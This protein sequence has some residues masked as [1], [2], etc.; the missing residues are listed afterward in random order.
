MVH[1]MTLSDYLHSFKSVWGA[2][3]GLSVTLAALLKFTPLVP[4]WPD[5]AGI[6]ASMLAVVA[7]LLGVSVGFFASRKPSA[8]A[9]L[10]VSGLVVSFILLMSYLYLLSWRV[11]IFHEPVGNTEIA[12]RIVVG[13]ETVNPEDSRKDPII[14]IDLYGVNAGA[15]TNRSV[16]NARVCL[17]GSYMAFY[18][19]LTFSLGLMQIDRIT[20]DG[21]PPGRNRA[22]ATV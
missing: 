2:L 6:G 12:H 10:G 20:D 4:P 21:H 8:A 22:S 5:E 13:T 17:L 15:W 14:L 3:V 11:V 9:V 18:L 7:C 1:T 19:V 16:T